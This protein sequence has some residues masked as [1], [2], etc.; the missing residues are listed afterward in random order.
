MKFLKISD[1]SDD[2]G[3]EYYSEPFYRKQLPS[4]LGGRSSLH[5]IQGIGTGSIPETL[6]L[7]IVDGMQAVEF[8]RGLAKEEGILLGIS[9][10]AA[11]AVATRLARRDEF[12]WENIVVILPDV[13]K[14]YLSIVLFD[15]IGI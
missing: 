3:H 8:A 13:C 5:K 7:S 2:T 14:R 4:S 11:G 10:D 15:G 1:L 12:T 6:D 9:S